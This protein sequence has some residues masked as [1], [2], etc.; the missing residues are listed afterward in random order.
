LAL[1]QL[2]PNSKITL[3]GE[4]GVIVATDAQLVFLSRENGKVDLYQ[5]DYVSENGEAFAAEPE[6]EPTTEDTSKSTSS[7]SKSSSGSSSSK[8]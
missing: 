8:S 4:S 3:D 2:V 5:T 1:E 6:P 7:S